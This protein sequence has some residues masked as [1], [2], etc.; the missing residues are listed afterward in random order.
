MSSPDY[1]LVKLEALKNLFR[2][3]YNEILKS[4][5]EDPVKYPLKMD[6][7]GH[8]AS[9]DGGQMMIGNGLPYEHNGD[10]AFTLGHEL[11]HNNLNHRSNTENL[12]L[13]PNPA[14]LSG[15]YQTEPF[16]RKNLELEADI[17]GAQAYQRAGYD[18]SKI[19]EMEFLNGKNPGSDLSPLDGHPSD[20]T[21]KDQLKNYFDS[22][23]L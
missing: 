4:I 12:L 8:N 5:G 17:G 15:F 10:I 16:Y 22:R 3:R 7:S 20:Q 9:A 19:T 13:N 18:P 21:R 1:E 14:M 11:A 2:P 23:G 6:F